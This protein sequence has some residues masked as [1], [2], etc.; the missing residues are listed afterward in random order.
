MP[1][2]RASAVAVTG[3][4]TTSGRRAVAVAAVAVAL[5]GDAVAYAR[6]PWLSTSVSVARVPVLVLELL[7]LPRQ[8][9]PAGLPLPLAVLGPLLALVLGSV[10][11]PLLQPLLLLMRPTADRH[12]RAVADANI[13]AMLSLAVAAINTIAAM[14]TLC[15][16]AIVSR[17]GGGRPRH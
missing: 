8:A 12:V 15:L 4:L 6:R 17:A 10:P 7:Q 1:A 5:D 9:L 3:P 2:V 13:A 16:A 14:L 11:A